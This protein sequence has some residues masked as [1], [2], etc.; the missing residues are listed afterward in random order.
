MI[1][2]V[3]TTLAVISAI[4]P[5]SASVRLIEQA[6]TSSKRPRHALPRMRMLVELAQKIDL[7]RRMVAVNRFPTW[8]T[9]EDAVNGGHVER[10]RLE[11]VAAEELSDEEIVA[12]SP[13]LR[14]LVCSRLCIEIE[15]GEVVDAETEECGDCLGN[16]FLSGVCVGGEED[17]RLED[18]SEICEECEGLGHVRIESR[19][20]IVSVHRLPMAVNVVQKQRVAS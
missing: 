19:P 1:P 20:G 15:D 4:R 5:A 8:R 6:Y 16:G 12:L 2:F 14:E 17:E 3:L 10:T 13:K 18:G 7:E 11:Y 9:Y